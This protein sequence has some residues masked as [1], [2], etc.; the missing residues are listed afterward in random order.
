MPV[1]KF[2]T[3]R[4]TDFFPKESVVHALDPNGVPFVSQ[5]PWL[6]SFSYEAVMSKGKKPINQPER[7]ENQPVG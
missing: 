6:T 1:G 5:R 7:P 3:I 4:I 2:L